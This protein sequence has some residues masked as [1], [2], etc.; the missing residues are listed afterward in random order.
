[1]KKISIVIFL[2][3]MSLQSAMG[4]YSCTGKV[5]GLTVSPTGTL[6]A[7]KIAGLKW[8]LICNTNVTKKGISTGTCRS[9]YALL[10]LAQQSKSDVNLWFKSA[11]SIPHCLVT[12]HPAWSYLGDSQWYFGPQIR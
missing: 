2:L 3:M 9:I 8:Q 10:L 4:N 1:M 12:D 7:E 6:A 5:F 11:D